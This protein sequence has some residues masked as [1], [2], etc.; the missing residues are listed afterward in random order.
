MKVDLLL[1]DLDGTLADTSRDVAGAMNY[2]LRGEGLPELPV[3]T[4]VRFVGHGVR[5]LI[6]RSLGALGSSVDGAE[7]RMY[8]RFLGWYRQHMLDQ[9]RLYP[10]VADTLERLHGRRMAVVTNK[11]EEPSRL[12]L[13]GL[14]VA[15]RF[16]AVV[17]GDS[18]DRKKPD[19]LPVTY[20]LERFGLDASR[21]LLVGDTA[22]DIATAQAAGIRSCVVTYG[23]AYQEDLSGADASIDAFPELVALLDV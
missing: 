17:G 18:L 4:I 3:E 19:P 20:L 21:T 23:Y 1:F 10:G 16:S 13:E 14:G 12:I 7:D 5:R 9:T 15:S 8:E 2:V 22:V 11:P 6:E